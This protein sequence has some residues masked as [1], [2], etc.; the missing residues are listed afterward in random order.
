VVYH[1]DKKNIAH[2]GTKPSST[3]LDD[4]SFETGDFNPNANTKSTGKSSLLFDALI[5]KECQKM[6]NETYESIARS[7]I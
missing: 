2:E 1:N 6:E 7:E 3:I 5:S 4:T